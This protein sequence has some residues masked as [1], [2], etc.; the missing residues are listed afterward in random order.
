MKVDLQAACLQMGFMKDTLRAL[1]PFS[2]DF[3]IQSAKKAIDERISRFEG[4]LLL[5]SKDLNL[6][7]CQEDMLGLGMVA[8]DMD[9]PNYL[10]ELVHYGQAKINS[11]IAQV[12]QSLDCYI[13][14][15]YYQE[16]SDGI[17]NCAS[18]FDPHGKEIGLYRKVHIPG[19]EAFQLKAGN[20]FPVFETAIG[21]IGLLVCYDDNFP[22]AAT[23][24]ML[25]GADIICH[26]TLA[27]P[28]A[29]RMQTR[30]YDN[31]VYYLSAARS[32][33]MITGPTGDILYEA[34][35]AEGVCQPVFLKAIA[36]VRTFSKHYD[37]LYSGFSDKQKRFLAARL[38]DAY[39]RA[40]END[41]TPERN[42]SE[43]YQIHVKE[44]KAE[45]A[46]EV[47]DFSWSEMEEE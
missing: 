31:Q 30:A 36:E 40:P 43:I 42:L 4:S 32:H 28:I 5:A 22:E 47:T 14:A 3:S 37:A 34:Q 1:N 2:V 20:H 23:S 39:L 21:R 19:A 27:K 46:E 11:M 12:S 26:P 18:L 45:L 6:I 35:K 17:Y 41:H 29:F 13:V 8:T 7:V 44:S 38:P 9:H 25:Q 33:S 15:S 16:M 24:L 10:Q